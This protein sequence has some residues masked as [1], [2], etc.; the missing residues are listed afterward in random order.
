MAIN[1]IPND[2]LAGAGSPGIRIQSPRPNRPASRAG[3]QFFDALPQGAAAPATPQFL[4]WQCREGAVRA[5]EAFEAAAGP[6]SAWQGNR[7]RIPL[8]QNAV[9]QLGANPEPN[10]FYNR[11]SVQFFQFT[12]GGKTTFSG[13]STDVVAHEVGHGILDALRPQLI[14]VDVLEVGAFHEAFGD[15]IALLTALEDAASAAAVRT[16]IASPN[17]LET[18]SED[19]SDAIRRVDPGHNAAAPRHA[20]NT[21]QW[22]LPTSLPSDGGPGVLI[23]EEHSFA[24]IFSGAFYDLI[25][26]LAGAAPT[27]AA[28]KTAARKAVRLLAE[29]ARTAPLTARFLQSVGRAMVMADEQ[30]NGGAN[31]TAI[32]AAFAGHG[33]LLGSSAMLAPLAAL[34]GSGPALSARAATLGAATRRDLVSR[35]GL[36][37][38]VKM[39]AAPLVIGGSRVAQAIVQREVSLAKISPKLKGVVARV[40][41]SVLVGES[42]GRAAVLG[43][44]PVMSAMNDEVLS[45]AEGLLKHKRIEFQPTKRTAAKGRPAPA[46]GLTHEVATVAGKR[47]LRRVGFACVCGQR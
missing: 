16:R 10:A 25:L 15:C 26:K 39:L 33:V 22:Q 42:G 45:F 38:S 24:Q 46:S 41:E 44:M 8:I 3:F 34:S 40:M 29:A 7:K 47:Q 23:N 17:F 1:F 9:V 31:R 12:G 30:L 14:E 37:G 27:V 2:P 36:K 20:L 11:A 5:V 43:A 6:L 28:L 35:L 21:I 19:L 13:E 32:G 18:T 4:F